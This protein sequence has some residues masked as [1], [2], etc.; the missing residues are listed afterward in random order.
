M[1]PY[2]GFLHGQDPLAVIA[3]T[4]EH[5]KTILANFGVDADRSPE[6]GKWSARQVLCHMA[7]TEIVF[8]FRLR[9]ALSEA[10]HIIQ[11]F[12]QD[13]WAARYESYTAQAAVELFAAVRTW[14]RLLIAGVTEQEM[15]KI[16]NHPERG[17]MTFST[18]VETMGG[19][20]L[21]HI[22]QLQTIA[23]ALEG[24]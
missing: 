5:L 11:P 20:D 18:V 14:N 13:G 6:P 17:D 9:Q 16:L 19:H 7:D 1:N 4:P 2:A 22:N 10:R 15:Q 3:S 8:A 23:A 12:D 21:N 24:K